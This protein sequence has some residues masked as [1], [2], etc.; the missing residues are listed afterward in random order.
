MMVAEGADQSLPCGRPAQLGSV[1]CEGDGEQSGAQPAVIFERCGCRVYR[2][3]VG[4]FVVGDT[5]SDSLGDLAGGGGMIV[6]QVADFRE[7]PAQQLSLLAVRVH[8]GGEK[9]SGLPGAVGDAGQTPSG[10]GQRTA[11]EVQVC[12][13]VGP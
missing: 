12:P 5:H 1:S 8:R 6:E 10:V 11:V 9:A 7:F 3:R 2:V 13:A 4:V